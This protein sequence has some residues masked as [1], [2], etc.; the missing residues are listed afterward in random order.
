MNMQLIGIENENEFYPAGFFS[1]A[2][3]GELTEIIARWADEKGSDN[4]AQRLSA[5]VA[6]YL[7]MIERVRTMADR[8]ECPV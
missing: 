7:A 5:C 4:P 6:D 8:G 1:G 2:L 3:Q